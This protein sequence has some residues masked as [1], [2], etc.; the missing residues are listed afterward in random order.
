MNKLDSILANADRTQA[1]V[2]KMKIPVVD[3]SEHSRIAQQASNLSGKLAVHSRSVPAIPAIDIPSFPSPIQIGLERHAERSRQLQEAWSTRERQLVDDLKATREAQEIETAPK[4]ER[5]LEALQLT[6][7][8]VDLQRLLVAQQ[9]QIQRQVIL[10]PARAQQ[11]ADPP[12]HADE[13]APRVTR[14][15]APTELVSEACHT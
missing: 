1:M 3:V 11:T 9:A 2:D 14:P 12:C 6:R 15:S 13:R 8:G 5:E 7:E 4:V 10:T